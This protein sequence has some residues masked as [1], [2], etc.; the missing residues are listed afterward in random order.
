MTTGPRVL[1][2]GQHSD[3]LVT[4]LAVQC[5]EKFDDHVGHVLDSVALEHGDDDHVEVHGV[6]LLLRLLD[7]PLCD[8]FNHRNVIVTIA[9]IE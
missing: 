5:V 3:Q 4:P 8:R 7:S 9:I 2:I 6:D 1:S